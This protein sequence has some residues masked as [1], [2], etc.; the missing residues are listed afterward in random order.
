M[1][2]LDT[3]VAAKEKVQ[4][5]EKGNLILEEKSADFVQRVI[6][7]ALPYRRDLM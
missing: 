7:K 5:L 2:I 4:I 3:A 6:Y 1:N